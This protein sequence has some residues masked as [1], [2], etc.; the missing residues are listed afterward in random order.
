MSN[1]I[2]QFQPTGKLYKSNS[3][4]KN[5]MFNISLIYK[6]D[7]LCQ[8]NPVDLKEFKPLDGWIESNEP[9]EHLDSVFEKIL[10]N[11][12]KKKILCF[13]YKDKT[14]AY[15]FGKDSDIYIDCLFDPKIGIFGSF[16]EDFDEEF[17][18]QKLL[19]LNRTYDLIIFRHYLEHFKYPLKLLKII[20][21]LVNL[22]GLLYLEVPDCSK[23]ILQ[24]NPLFL[25]EQHVSYFDKNSIS[26]IIENSGVS[27][28]EI[29]KYGEDIEPSIGCFC[30]GLCLDK[31]FKKK[32][33][34]VDNTN[35]IKNIKFNFK[36]YVD[37]WRH[38]LNLKNR[39]K[40]I[41]GI[42]HN[43]DR[44]L[45]IINSYE[46]IDYLIDDSKDKQGKFLINFDKAIISLDHIKNHKDY[47]FILATNDRSLNNISDKLNKKYGVKNFLSIFKCPNNYV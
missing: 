27:N 47:D 41:L 7:L 15:R 38:Y 17:I 1:Q 26:T 10:I 29:L 24:G 12:N 45:Q 20:R 30:Y 25:W 3:F 44:F 42:G 19:K 34:E 2:F 5:P 4:I 32:E 9:E 43:A 40:I 33:L 23:F 36:K 35:T 8:K 31:S 22:E 37:S 14:L 13:S 28:Y 16:P 21:K 46:N 6:E 18:I 11:G 39:K